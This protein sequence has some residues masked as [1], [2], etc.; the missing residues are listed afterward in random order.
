[1][2]QLVAP[3]VGLLAAASLASAQPSALRGTV[4]VDGS[5][6]VFPITEAAAAEFRKEFPN[7]NVTVG[8]SGT[9]GGFKRFVKG[10]TDISDA[11]RPI[12]PEEFALAKENG[13]QFIEIP[14]ALDGLSV[15]VNP[16]NTWASQ[17]SVEDLQA[18]YLEDGGARKWSDINPKWPAETIKVYSPGT[19]TGTFDYFQEVT[20]PKGKSF[21]A[22]MSTS[23]DDNVLVTGV[24]GDKFAIGYFGAS[25]YFENQD[26]LRAVPIVNPDTGEAVLPEP[27]Y[28]VDGSYAP[29]SRPLFI[30]VNAESLRRPEVRKFVEFYLEHDGELAERVDYVALPEDVDSA[31]EEFLKSRVTGSV[32]V[33]PDHAKRDGRLR[34]LY[35]RQNVVDTD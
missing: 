16:A 3:L 5:S 19:D 2:R 18:I 7:V 12:K 14:V 9:G 34:E 29:L 11:S 32:Y 30:Y 8:V 26:K 22:D 24:T 31:A 25:Y 27:Q 17:L 21:R 28:V 23:E 13:V 35:V 33:T 1:M 10:E 15:V 4:S 6:T 20:L